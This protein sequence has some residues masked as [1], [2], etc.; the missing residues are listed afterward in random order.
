MNRNGKCNC[1]CESGG[2]FGSRARIKRI[3]SYFF[4]RAVLPCCVLAC[5]AVTNAAAASCAGDVRTDLL[6]GADIPS[7]ACAAGALLNL[8]GPCL[9]DEAKGA[10]ARKAFKKMLSDSIALGVIYQCVFDRKEP[11]PDDKFI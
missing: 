8:L 3:F 11:E 1:I 9:G 10:P 6:Y 5:W 2:L 4:R 7:Q